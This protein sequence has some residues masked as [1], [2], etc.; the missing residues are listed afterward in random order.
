MHTSIPEWPDTCT[1]GLHL[2]LNPALLTLLKVLVTDRHHLCPHFSG[3]YLWPV[4]SSK[5]TVILSWIMFEQPRK[6]TQNLWIGR[7][8]II[9]IV[10]LEPCQWSKHS[11]SYKSSPHIFNNEPNVCMIFDLSKLI[12]PYRYQYTCMC[13]VGSSKYEIRGI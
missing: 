12:A 6:C 9:F 1:C 4:T 7:H 13:I 11:T 8:G 5:E 10:A 2:L 3:V